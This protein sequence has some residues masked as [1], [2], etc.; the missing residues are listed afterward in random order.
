CADAFFRQTIGFKSPTEQGPPTWKRGRPYQ[1]RYTDAHVERTSER[2]TWTVLLHPATS[3]LDLLSVVKNS[4]LSPAMHTFQVLP[5][6]QPP[7]GFDSVNRAQIILRS[8]DATDSGRPDELITLQTDDQG[9]AHARLV[10]GSYVA[11]ASAIGYD[12]VEVGFDAS[13]DK[14]NVTLPLAAASGFQ[15]EVND[16]QHEAIPVKATIYSLDADH[17]K[18]GLSSTRTFIE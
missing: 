10:P 5:G 11:V 15:A 13:G 6:T 12:S 1:L 4:N 3:P 7:E 9:V 14:G 8:V 2:L 17:P 16:E 18:F